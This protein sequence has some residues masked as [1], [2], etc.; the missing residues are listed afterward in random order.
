MTV[1]RVV[2]NFASLP[3]HLDKPVILLISNYLG[4]ATVYYL[5][6]GL[7]FI[8]VRLALWDKKKQEGNYLIDLCGLVH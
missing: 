8:Y 6:L 1:E 5:N 7:N 4:Y 2:D 3:L